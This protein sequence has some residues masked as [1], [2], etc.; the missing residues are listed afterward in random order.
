MCRITE[1]VKALGASSEL[2]VALMKGK[3]TLDLQVTYVKKPNWLILSEV[4][5]DDA[6][7]M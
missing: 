2:Y 4:M 7:F 5:K 3:E 6:A 1:A